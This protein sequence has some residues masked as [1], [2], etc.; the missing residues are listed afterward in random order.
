MKKSDLSPATVK[1]GGITPT[2][3]LGPS[4][5]LSAVPITSGCPPNSRLPV[6][7]AQDDD[8]VSAAVVFIVG[9][10][11]AEDGMLPRVR[12]R[13]RTSTAGL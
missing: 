1:P 2:I 9:V 8:A 3:V 10:R 12:G 4:A 13:R 6:F 5:V 11:P 7:V